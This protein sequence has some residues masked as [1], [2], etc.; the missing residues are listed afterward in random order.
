MCL[1]HYLKQVLQGML[2]SGSCPGI[3]TLFCQIKF[4]QVSFPSVLAGLTSNLI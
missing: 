4:I 2:K 3:L 1:N